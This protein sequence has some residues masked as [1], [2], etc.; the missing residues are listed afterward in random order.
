MQELT[1]W[2]HGLMSSPPE[3]SKL[4]WI[5]GVICLFFALFVLWE[6]HC[7]NKRREHEE[8]F[9]TQ[10]FDVKVAAFGFSDKEKR[11]LDKIIRMSSFE[12]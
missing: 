7:I 11:T 9:G 3:P 2:L 4:V 5:V 10:I 6:I 1:Q 12:N 8:M